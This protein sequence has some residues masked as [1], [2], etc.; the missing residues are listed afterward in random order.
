MR[1]TGRNTA[2]MAK[3]T[4]NQRYILTDYILGTIEPTHLIF[5]MDMFI[6]K[7][8]KTSKFLVAMVT[9]TIATTMI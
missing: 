5:N 1:E 6:G 3:I 2:I 4:R 8:K 7:E 9:A